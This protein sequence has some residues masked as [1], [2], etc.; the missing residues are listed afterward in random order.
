MHSDTVHLDHPTCDDRTR[1]SGTMLQTV[2]IP[3][4]VRVSSVSITWQDNY[5]QSYTVSSVSSTPVSRST[6]PAVAQVTA[7][8]NCCT[9]SCSRY[10]LTVRLYGRWFNAHG[11]RITGKKSSRTLHRQGKHRWRTH[12]HRGSERVGTQKVWKRFLS[13]QVRWSRLYLKLVII[14]Y[15]EAK[16]PRVYSVTIVVKSRILIEGRISP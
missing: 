13:E 9:D 10:I 1:R 5:S 4:R 11:G 7:Y 14:M 16:A 8:G 3:S 12:Y 6:A 2:T 15:P